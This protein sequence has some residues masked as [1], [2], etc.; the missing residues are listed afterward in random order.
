MIKLPRARR[1][2]DILA[3]AGRLSWGLGTGYLEVLGLD[4][5]ISWCLGA[6]SEVIGG[7]GCQ[8]IDI[9]VVLAP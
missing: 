9:L 1:N 5:L 8:N 7:S 2:L 6:R 4:I 3:P